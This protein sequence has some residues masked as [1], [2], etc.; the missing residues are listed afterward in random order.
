MPWVC[1]VSFC[2]ASAAGDLPDVPQRAA[3][4]ES[5][6][7]QGHR[8]A[9]DAAMHGVSRTRT[10]NGEPRSADPGRSIEGR[11]ARPVIVPG[12]AAASHL[13]RRLIGQE[14]PPMPWEGG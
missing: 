4:Q 6:L 1:G 10:V 7:L 8:A 13:Y 2:L 9:S 5:L 12:D 14:T 3:G 11:E